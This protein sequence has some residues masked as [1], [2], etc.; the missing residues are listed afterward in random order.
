MSPSRLP[1]FPLPIV[2]FPGT[3][4]A[5]HIFEPRYRQMLADCRAGDGRFGLS[6]VVAQPP[7]PPSRGS[8]G[9]TATI[10]TV[11]PLP[12]GRS[13]IAVAGGQRYAVVRYVDTDRQYLVA[14]V[15]DVNDDPWFDHEG[16][17][18]LADEVRDRFLRY[19]ATLGQAQDEI[20]GAAP[21]EDPGGLSFAV[22][23]ALDLDLT[24]KLRLLELRSTVARL[25]LLRDLLGPLTDAARQ[26]ALV[27]RQAKRNGR[28]RFEQ[29]LDG[30]GA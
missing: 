1:I 24:L 3:A 2:L 21:P 23:A 30:T 27:H 18:R 6:P 12:D 15:D 26:R 7:S 20:A 14:E 28:R 16:V 25:A 29:P 17:T 4:Q 11:V 5:L 10:Q 19:L 22:S 9:C 8:I 13:N